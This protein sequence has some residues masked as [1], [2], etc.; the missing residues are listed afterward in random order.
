LWEARST[1]TLVYGT[2]TYVASTFSAFIIRQKWEVLTGTL[3]IWTRSV[4]GWRSK[5]EH[6]T[7]MWSNYIVVLLT[8]A[9]SG[10]DAN[11]VF[12]YPECTGQDM[13]YQP[14]ASGCGLPNRLPTRRRKKRVVGGEETLE[15]EFPWMVN[16]QLRQVVRIS[17]GTNQTII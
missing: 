6:Y 3:L 11:N 1:P 15:N 2:K 16:I 9:I 7:I 14:P 8:F 5:S 4:D 12:N 10:F 17:G 13:C